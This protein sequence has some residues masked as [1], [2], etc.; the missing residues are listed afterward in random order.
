M[1]ILQKIKGDLHF[2]ELLQGSSIALLFRLLSALASY[3]LIFVLARM[4]GAE[5]V[6]VYNTSWTILMISAVI[7]KLGFDTS[8]VKFMAVSLGQRSYNKLRVIYKKGFISVFISS[9]VMSLIIFGLSDFFTNWF[10]TKTSEK[11]VIQVVAFS[12]IP[13]AILSY[14]SE[15]L[16][17]LKKILPFSIYQ[18]VSI[19]FLTI[20]VLYIINYFYHDQ[21]NI[22]IAIFISLLILSVASV[23][24]FKSYVKHYPQ[25]DSFYS[26]SVPKLKEIFKTTIPMML[27]NS[28]F[29][30]MNWTDVLMLARLTNEETVGIYNTALK[31][32]AL[33]SIVLIAINSIAMPK[34]AELYAQN[35]VHKFRV[36]VKVV[37]FISFIVSL[38]VFLII[39]LWPDLILSTFGE[40]FIGGSSSMILLSIG[41]LFSSFSGA[42]INL[43]NMTGREKVTMYI[44]LVSI[45]INF[46]LNYTLIPIYGLN[47]AA[48][49]TF[50]STILWNILASICI[51]KYHSFFA[52]PV[53]RYTDLKKNFNVLFVKK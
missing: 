9:V 45:V 20:I 23:Y 10:F 39:I 22:V 13:F 40:E 26:S 24:T 33:N 32:A 3:V 51:Y 48:I 7:A 11:W 47:G 41:Q 52:Y 49:A 19:Y 46:I 37:S 38:P 16:K 14:N 15:S 17:G 1:T 2:R 29:L 8:I 28:L 43:L 53:L 6:G 21:K 42:T 34:F 36:V 25:R 30:I 31:I 5:G 50:V 18:N 27:T 12:V 35:N 4:Y 44:L